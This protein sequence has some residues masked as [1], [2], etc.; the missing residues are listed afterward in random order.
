MPNF[1]DPAE[2]ADGCRDGG[3]AILW[4]CDVEL[5]AQ[6]VIVL[7]DSG[8]DL[9]RVVAGCNDVVASLKRSRRDVEAQATA[10]AS[11]SSITGPRS[12]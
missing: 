3:L 11:D 1:A 2:P 9:E 7:T 4:A 10:C 8:R 6:Q 12:G 5:D